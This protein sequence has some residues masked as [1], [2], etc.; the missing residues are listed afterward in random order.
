MTG[1]TLFDPNGKELASAGGK[2]D[3]DPGD[4]TGGAAVI[5]PATALSSSI[6]RYVPPATARQLRD[7]S[8]PGVIHV[9]FRI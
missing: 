4:P 6:G 8:M 9:K 2:L 7:V 5:T 1:E 3:L